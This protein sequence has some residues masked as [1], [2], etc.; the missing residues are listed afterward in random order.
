MEKQANTSKIGK[1]TK[2]K[3][4]KAKYEDDDSRDEAIS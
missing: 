4:R 2:G 1:T 3:T